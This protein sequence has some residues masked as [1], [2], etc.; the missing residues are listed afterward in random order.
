VEKLHARAK[1]VK[2][3]RIDV[4]D[5]RAHALCLDLPPDDGTDLGP[6]ALELSL[7][8]LAGC[9]AT[10]FVLTAKKM[11]IKV[12]DLEVNVEAA[13]SEEARTIVE[14]ILAI[15]VKAD[16]P[17]D[18]VQRLHKL[19]VA[20]CPVGILYEKAGVRTTYMIEVRK[21]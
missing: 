5:G 16:A 10:I 8:S 1:L 14:A 13:K 12:K 18:R 11:R 2:D 15:H 7:M 20:S 3:F 17:E 4:D 9:Y 21:G 19:T 6:S